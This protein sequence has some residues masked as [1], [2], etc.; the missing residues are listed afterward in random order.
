MSWLFQK[1]ATAAAMGMV[2][3]ASPLIVEAR[4]L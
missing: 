1:P 3:A 4:G 2:L